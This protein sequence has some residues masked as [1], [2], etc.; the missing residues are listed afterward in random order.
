MYVHH[1]TVT[2]DSYEGKKTLNC[3][4]TSLW[5]VRHKSVFHEHL[6]CVMKNV[7]RLYWIKKQKVVSFVSYYARDISQH[8]NDDVRWIIDV[9]KL[10][11]I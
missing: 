1:S 2:P 9:K 10:L 8:V 3:I 7:L 6:T 5:N 4:Q 11:Y